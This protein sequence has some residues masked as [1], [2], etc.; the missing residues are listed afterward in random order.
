MG[1]IFYDFIPGERYLNSPILSAEKATKKVFN[2]RPEVLEDCG[3][4]LYIKNENTIFNMIFYDI[5]NSSFTISI[6]DFNHDEKKN[7]Y[8][9][10]TEEYTIDFQRFIKMALDLCKDFCIAEIKTDTF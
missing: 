5:K 10:G 7:Y 9:S 2:P 6:G 8:G 1:F 4:C 3:Q